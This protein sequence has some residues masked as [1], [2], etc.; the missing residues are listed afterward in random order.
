MN[1][2]YGPPHV[3]VYLYVRSKVG[4]TI[5]QICAKHYKEHEQYLLDHDYHFRT[6]EELI[7]RGELSDGEERQKPPTE[8]VVSLR[9]E[10]S[11]FP[12][13]DDTGGD[14]K[15]IELASERPLRYYAERRPHGSAPSEH[16]GSSGRALARREVSAAQEIMEASPNGTPASRSGLPDSA[17]GTPAIVEPAPLDVW[18][19]AGSLM[20]SDEQRLILQPP[21]DESHV[22][23][24]Y[25]GI[26]FV[27]WVFYWD[28]LLRAFSPYVPAL[29]PTSKPYP[30]ENSLCRDYI[31]IVNGQYVSHATGECIRA[32]GNQK[33]TYASAVEGCKSDAITKC[34]K[35]LGM[36]QQLFD[37]TWRDYY[38]ATYGE[39][40]RDDQNR[41][42]WRKKHLIEEHE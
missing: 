2:M 17:G 23:I 15:A 28:R 41:K 1:C 35:S 39:E 16:S 9:A 37:P 36:G 7:A 14:Q 12:P 40:Y 10:E 6:R 21:F 38:L 31:L 29:I 20:L 18:Q 22:Q 27:P 11:Q 19:R 32:G 8:S 25:D 26:V 42:R 5:G 4:R 3:G 33:L 13:S 34:C 30:V 24:R